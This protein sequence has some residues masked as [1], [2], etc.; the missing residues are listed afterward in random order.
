MSATELALQQ[1]GAL[2]SDHHGWLYGWLRQKLGCSHRAAD[3]A[4]DT[5][6]RLLA[7]EEQLALHEPRAFLTTVA[8]RVLA[9]HWRREQIERAYLEALAHA[10]QA[11]APS[12][13][14]RAI[15]LETLIEIDRL[16][17]GL[18]A[19]AKR[20]F[21]LAQLDGMSQAE[22][23]VELDISISTVKRHLVRAGTQCYFA[24]VQD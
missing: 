14:E 12:P 11:F 19:Q 22:I 16:L 20:A 15:L 13:E 24:L 21:L 4:Q 18:P 5:F 17:A 7:R 3:L 8:Q 2:Y 23:A 6:L 10:P 1:V 9:N